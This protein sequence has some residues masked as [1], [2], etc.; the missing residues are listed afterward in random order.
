M[1]ET[2]AEL[3]VPETPTGSGSLPKWLLGVLAS[4][5]LVLASF[6]YGHINAEASQGEATRTRLSILEQRQAD[7]DEWRHDV[8][9]QLR[10]VNL[11]LDALLRG[12]R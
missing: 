3:E 12:K 10:E 8:K 7:T 6:W 9:E 5:I 4:G 1:S 11:K 2:H